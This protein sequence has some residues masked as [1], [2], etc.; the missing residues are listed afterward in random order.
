[1]YSFR[2]YFFWNHISV[3]RLYSLIIWSFFIRSCQLGT[4]LR[5]TVLVHIQLQLSWF[6]YFSRKIWLRTYLFLPQS[7]PKEQSY[8]WDINRCSASLNVSLPFKNSLFITTFKI[9]YHWNLYW[10]YPHK[11]FLLLTQSLTLTCHLLLDFSNTIW[12]VLCAPSGRDAS[13]VSRSLVR[14]VY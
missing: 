10:V 1:M 11:H 2:N 3:L 6:S 7:N 13:P 4:V 14:Y 8:F 9:V 12:C 5:Y